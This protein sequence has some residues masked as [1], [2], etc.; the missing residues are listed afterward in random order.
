V[1]GGIHNISQSAYSRKDSQEEFTYVKSWIHSSIPDFAGISIDSRTIK[2]KELFL[3]FPG[4]STD[5][6]DFIHSAIL[7]GCSGVLWE[8][9][10]FEWNNDWSIPNLPVKN[11]RA[12]AGLLASDFFGNPSE[13]LMTIGVTGTNGKT[14]VT[15]WLSDALTE[16]G[17]TCGSIGTLGGNLAGKQVR[18]EG[19]DGVT[20]PNSIV[21]QAIL[22]TFLMRNA[23][24][25]AIEVSSHALSQDRVN[26]VRFEVGVF[27]NLSRDHLDY[28][29]DMESY[30]AAKARLFEDLA[31]RC[32]VINI[33]DEFGRL[34]ANQLISRQMRVMTYGF[35][36][37]ADFC[38]KN[39]QFSPSSTSFEL[40]ARSKT[41]TFE[42]PIS[43]DFNV[44]NLL[45]VIAVLS[46]V[47][48]SIK[49]ILGVLK[50][51]KAPAGRLQIVDHDQKPLVYVD[52]AHTPDALEKVLC[53][54]QKIKQP[55]SRI[56]CVFGAGGDRDKEKRVLMGETVRALSDVA[57]VTNDNPRSEN[58]AAIAN[59]IV[60]ANPDHFLIE[61]DRMRAIQRAVDLSTTEDLIL[62]AGKGHE[63]YQE[64][65]GERLKFSDI[66]A[67]KAALARRVEIRE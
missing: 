5:G 44:S 65:K 49:K 19:L 34:L 32:A 31:I 62:V 33:D 14:S 16:L 48:Y 55:K 3:A 51:T 53:T 42:V 40:R 56:I 22:Q 60:G 58:P 43:G 21:I 38:A 25:A 10:N 24:S 29:Q 63:Q 57:I 11:L 28:H 2:K 67:V 37:D 59:Q 20:T 18:Q 46:Y 23:K 30:G 13:K 47:G 6:R 36:A 41:Y 15:K 26:G 66:D 8:P 45:A 64:I 50:K 4:A 52:Y 39:I 35:D 1:T 61:L 17:N 12:I 27:T 9:S 54:L 7:S